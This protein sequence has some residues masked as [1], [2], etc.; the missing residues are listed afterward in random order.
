MQRKNVR[1]VHEGAEHLGAI[2]KDGTCASLQIGGWLLCHMQRHGVVRDFAEMGKG[3]FPAILALAQRSTSTRSLTRA[4]FDTST[5][6]TQL[7]EPLLRAPTALRRS[8]SQSLPSRHQPQPAPVH[9][10]W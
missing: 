8:A 9:R 7:E 5:A 1:E 10:A 2:W 3:A 6:T 4:F